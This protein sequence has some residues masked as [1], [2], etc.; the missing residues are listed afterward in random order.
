MF[1]KSIYPQNYWTIYSYKVKCS[2]SSAF[3]YLQ[4]AVTIKDF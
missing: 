4:Q 1:Q 2:L 3:F